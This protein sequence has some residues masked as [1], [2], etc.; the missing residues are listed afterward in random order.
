MASRR[1]LYSS[2]VFFLLAVLGSPIANAQQCSLNRECGDGY[3][4]D[5]GT[6]RKAE[7]VLSRDGT[8]RWVDQG[9]GDDNNPG[10]ESRP[11]K[12]ISRAARAG[13]L[14]PGDAVLIRAGTYREEVRPRAGGSQSNG[15]AKYVTYAAYPGDEVTV[16]G[17]DVVNRPDR[18][19]TGWKQQSDGTWR[20]NWI[21]PALRAEG[22]YLAMR[23][24]ELF[25][26]NGRVLVQ[27]GGE[28]QPPLQ[29][30][31]FW[32]EGPD[33][34]PVAVYVRTFNGSNPNERTMEVGIR[35]E[36]FYSYD[37][38]AANCGNGA[39]GY[40]R[41]IGLRFT[42]ATTKRQRM[43]V[44]SGRQGSL[45]EEVE[46][47]WNNAGGIKLSGRDHVVRNSNASY[48][49]IEG[50]GGSGCTRCTVEHSE[51][52][53][54]HWK[55]S[56]DNN[57]AHGGGGKWTQSREN[58]FRYNRYVGNEGSGVWLDNKAVHNEVYGNY[59][60]GSLK[61]GIQVEHESDN[62]RIYNNVVVDTRY[63]SP[64]WNGVGISV[65][66]SDDNLVAYNTLMRNE[67]AGVRIAGDNREDAVRTTVYNNL[68]VDNLQARDDG[69]ERLREIQII[70][71]GPEN[72]LTGIDRVK[73]HRLDGNAYWYRPGEGQGD[74]ATFM[75]SPAPATG[76]NLY[77]NLI[78]DWRSAGAGYDRNGFV[79]DLSKETVVD[80]AD[81]DDGWRVL[82]G[83]QYNGRSVALPSGVSPILTD[84]YGERRPA[85]GGTI[86]AVQA[87]P[88]TLPPPP[89]VS[90]GS[91]G[92]SGTVEV[93]QSG[94][95]TWTRVTLDG[96][97]TDPVV[98]V[99]PPSYEGAH[100]TTV[101]VRDVTSSSFEVQL[102]EWDY[103][104]G[105]HVAETVSY[106]VVEAGAHTLAD[107]RRIEA[108]YLASVDDGWSRESFTSSFPTP[109]LVLPQ[110]TTGE[111]SSAVA[112]RLRSVG[113][114]GF[115]IS[116]KRRRGTTG[117]TQRS[118]WPTSLSRPGPP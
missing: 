24:R 90:D 93:E 43:A 44:C 20:H 83:S 82:I 79:T 64:I 65:S 10:T 53:Y 95:D 19:Y 69:G 23:R 73:S 1:P 11:W 86:G 67:G 63:W 105:A 70:G 34:A 114:G 110:V 56:Q 94:P 46:A 112:A 9:S 108:G 3:L 37:E 103:L 4:C 98:V 38:G 5:D 17:A 35:D 58:V 2:A 26:D 115:E 40:F 49:G 57:S 51:I 88:V 42:H 48:N 85:S 61:Q 68:F 71:N 74:L 32:V 100:P 87:G 101:R 27:Q 62:N 39:L 91:V 31:E 12:T 14:A 92:E 107:G 15:T 50:I 22:S 25:V 78:A 117:P 77:S 47:V 13:A 104:D 81:S 109:P 89:A 45:L 33:S 84:F 102:D 54:N 80:P 18:G 111:G 7:D 60:Q 72:G 75:L 59:V 21:W 52:S 16:S 41:L 113:S 29:N 8:V 118:A 66:V 99:G 6:C 96:S 36:L 116:S 106:L 76:G 97:Y 28:S 55:W 30:G